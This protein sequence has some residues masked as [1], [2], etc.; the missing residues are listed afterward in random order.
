MN[1][2]ILIIG[3][4]GFLGYNLAK[5]IKNIGCKIVLLC[6]KKNNSLKPIKQAEYI[7]CDISN[8]KKLKKKLIGDFDYFINFSGNINHQN[9]SQTYQTHYN[10]FKKLI[11]VLENKKIKLFIQAGS[12]LEYGKYSSPQKER[13]ISRPISHYGR[14]KYLASRFLMNKKKNFKY[15]I[16]RLYQIYGPYQKKDRLIPIVIN[17]CLKNKKF[18]CTEGNQKRDFLYIDDLIELLIKIIK[19]KKIK[20]DVYNVGCGR[21]VAV[22]NVIEKIN[23]IIKRGKPNFGGIIM[24]KDEVMSL[25]PNIKKI[26]KTFNWNPKTSM[27]KGLRKTINYYEKK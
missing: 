18:N 8:F 16:L 10:G 23:L 26:K 11:R 22:K 20:S 6:K 27:F 4:N 25:Y 24:R 15:I 1:K 2:K 17:S 14:A 12:S 3:A 5:K 19:T 21:A 7:Y 13:I 9:K